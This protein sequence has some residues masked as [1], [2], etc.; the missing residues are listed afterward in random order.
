MRNDRTFFCSELVAKAYKYL[1]VIED[2][3]TSCSLFY[4]CHFTSSGDSFLK[5]TPGTTIEPE[6]QIV[7]DADYPQDLPMEALLEQMQLLHE[8]Q[9]R[10]HYS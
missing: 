1:K 5:L 2:D 8:S 6:S 7:I 10:R 4:P 3:K 9:N